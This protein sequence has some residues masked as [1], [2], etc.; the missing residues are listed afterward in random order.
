MIFQRA[1]LRK[2]IENSSVVFEESVERKVFV[3]FGPMESEAGHREL[4]TRAIVGTA[5]TR[6]VSK[7]FPCG[8]AVGEL[9]PYGIVGGPDFGNIIGTQY[10]LRL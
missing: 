2:K 3:E 5:Q 9:N 1:K 8:S 7:Q 4:L 6:I 10:Y